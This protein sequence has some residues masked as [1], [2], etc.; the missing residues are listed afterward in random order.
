V[1]ALE[2]FLKDYS[3]HPS[4]AEARYMLA[5]SYKALGRAQEAYDTVIELLRLAWW[6][7][8]WR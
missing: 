3:R 6:P 1:N 8:R 2:R 5:S 7:Q 4:A